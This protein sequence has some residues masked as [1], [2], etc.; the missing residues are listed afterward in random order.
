MGYHNP[1]STLPQTQA[2]YWL[3][4][5]VIAAALFGTV[6]AVLD[7]I[8]YVRFADA[9]GARFVARWSLVLFL[10]GLIQVA[11]GIYLFLIPD[12]MGVW[13]V[14]LVQRGVAGIYAMGMAIA[15]I[16]NADGR[17]A[18]PSGLQLND[19]LDGGKAALWSL[20][21]VSVSTILAFFA[22]RLSF[23]LWRVELL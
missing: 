22:G 23:Y 14:T 21:M 19:A 13:V 4:A 9:P 17:V 18:G 5:A 1:R 15:L 12:R 3:A 8:E 11:Y 16:A 7:V 2:A 20:C 6:P 10:I